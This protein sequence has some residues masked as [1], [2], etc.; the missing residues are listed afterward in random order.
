MNSRKN[1]NRGNDSSKPAFKGRKGKPGKALSSKNVK[2]RDKR[3]Y[4]DYKDKVKKGDPLPTF[5]DEVRLN[6]YLSNAGVCSRR[7]ADTLIKTGVVSVNGEI[8]TEMGYCLL[9]TS[10]AADD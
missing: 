1:K 8:I 4:I 6:K 7:E 10:D 9:Y 3:K 5:S 2:S